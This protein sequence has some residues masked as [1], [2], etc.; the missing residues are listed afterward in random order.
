MGVDD[1]QA[2]HAQEKFLTTTGANTFPHGIGGTG[3]HLVFLWMLF[4]DCAYIDPVVFARLLR[5][6]TLELFAVTR[7]GVGLQ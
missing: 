3:F 6:H 2:V 5:I 4:V 7:V 1:H